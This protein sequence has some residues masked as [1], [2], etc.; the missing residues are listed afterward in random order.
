MSLV[1][2]NKFLNEECKALREQLA[3]H[4]DVGIEGRSSMFGVTQKEFND[5]TVKPKAAKMKA[6]K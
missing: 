2:E 5:L 4:V 1:R 3:D 6:S